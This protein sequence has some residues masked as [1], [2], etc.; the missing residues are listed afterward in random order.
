M[1][2]YET[3]VKIARAFGRSLWFLAFCCLLMP[4]AA[5]ASKSNVTCV[6]TQTSPTSD[7]VTIAEPPD[8]GT[9]K[10]TYSCK[11]S[12]VFLPSMIDTVN[13]L[14]KGIPATTGV[15]DTLMINPG[16]VINVKSHGDGTGKLVA[17][18]STP[19][20]APTEGPEGTFGPVTWGPVSGTRG[21][22]VHTTHGTTNFVF[23]SD[24]PE[25]GTM[26][27]FGTGLVAVGFILRRRLA[28]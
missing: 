8:T 11:V 19:T 14:E 27:L 5:L 20:F 13:V 15:S 7:T 22:G 26:L 25:P 16:G 28:V 12:N 9:K 18:F 3:A 23:F 10:E 1:G 24:T 2:P 17:G 4:G 21:K 6:V